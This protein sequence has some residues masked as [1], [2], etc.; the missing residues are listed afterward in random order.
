MENDV[1]GIMVAPGDSDALAKQ[2]ER[3]ITQPA[4]RQAL[5]ENGLRR[6][7]QHFDVELGIDQLV[8]LFAQ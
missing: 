5:G 3:L 4:L 1:N 7:H 8:T 2:L 6:L